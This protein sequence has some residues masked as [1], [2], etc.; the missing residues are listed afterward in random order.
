MAERIARSAAEF[1]MVQSQVLYR[2]DTMSIEYYFK[3]DHKNRQLAF[4]FSSLGS[5]ILNR[6]INGGDYLIENGFDVVNFNSNRNDWFQNVPAHIFAA[7][8][9]IDRSGSYDK[10]VAMGSSMGGYAAIC[11]SKSLGCDIALAYVPQHNVTIQSDP[12][13]A[14]FVENIEWVYPISRETISETCRFCIV[15]DNKDLY[16]KM[17][18]Q[19]FKSIIPESNYSEIVLRYAGHAVVFYL[20]EL[21]LLKHVSLNVL[22]GVPVQV[23]HLRKNRRQSR[24]YLTIT[25]D[26][27]RQKNHARL[28]AQVTA[29]IKD[30]YEPPPAIRWAL[31]HRTRLLSSLAEKMEMF[32]LWKMNFD[33]QFYTHLYWDVL[34]MG[35]SPRLHYIRYGRPEQRIIRFRK[36]G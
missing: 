36:S 35:L 3:P 2:S 28:S 5:K 11:F 26:H 21:G 19:Y 4:V 14:G 9:A 34:P 17:H 31:A 23:S 22:M 13:F 30:K 32:R 7:I 15:Y 12:R 20:L 6:N 24:Q 27:L 10:R 25:A 8:H 1:A 16:D 33:E 18:V 29:L